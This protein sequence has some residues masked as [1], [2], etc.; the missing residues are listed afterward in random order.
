VF[1][2]TIHRWFWFLTYKPEIWSHAAVI[3]ALVKILDRLVQLKEYKDK[4][5][6][7]LNNEI[8]K[9]TANGSAQLYAAV[10][11][12]EAVHAIPG[13][14]NLPRCPLESAT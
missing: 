4:R 6:S 13:I 12:D 5:L 7:E 11:E 2:P 10:R 14:S 3:D 1:L 9:P 8:V